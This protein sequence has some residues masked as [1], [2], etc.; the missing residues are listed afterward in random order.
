MQDTPLFVG[1]KELADIGM[2]QIL[3]AELRV[4]VSGFGVY[5]I[6]LLRLS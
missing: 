3:D 1:F 6:A 5:W 4:Q 2:V